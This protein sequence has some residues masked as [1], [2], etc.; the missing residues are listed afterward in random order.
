MMCNCQCLDPKA[1]AGIVDVEAC[2]T[3]AAASKCPANVRSSNLQKQRAQG[4]AADE[5]E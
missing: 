4:N 1:E 3:C 5:Y 2:N